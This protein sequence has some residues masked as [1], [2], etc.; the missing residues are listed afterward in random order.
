MKQILII[1]LCLISSSVLF[2]QGKVKKGENEGVDVMMEAYLKANK[3]MIDSAKPMIDFFLKYDEKD[4]AKAPSQSDFDELLNQMG[5]MDEVQNDKS[6]L[7]KEDAFQFINAYI[8]ADKNIGKEKVIQPQTNTE[9]ELQKELKKAEKLFEDS[10]P[11]I[12]KLMKQAEKEAEKINTNPNLIPYGDFR[13][14][15]KQMKPELTEN[16]IKAAYDDLM[17][18]LGNTH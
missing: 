5:I 14:K 13:K 6:G 8:N 18:T 7:T 4:S 15:A 9:S 3:G 12:E 10:M 11:E 1:V 2:A 16:E 17:K